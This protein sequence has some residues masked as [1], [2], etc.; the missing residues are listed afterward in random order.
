MKSAPLLQSEHQLVTQGLDSREQCEA[1]DDEQIFDHPTEANSSFLHVFFILL[2][3][4]IGSGTLLVPYCYTSGIGTAL[5]ISAIFAFVALSAM[6][7]LIY[8]STKIKRY[9]YH[10]M[11]EYC[12]GKK[13]V[14]ILNIMI[15]LV[16][17]GSSMIY[18][19]WNGRLLNYLIGSKHWLFG[20]NEF[21]VYAVTALIAFPLTLFRSISALGKFTM[22][23]ICFIVVLI[24]HAFYWFI[25]DKSQYGFDPRNELRFFDF[26][27]YNVIITALSVNSMAYN[28]HINLFSCLQHLKNSTIRRGKR[29]CYS[30]IIVA[31]ILYNLFGLFTYLDL[32][33]TLGNGSSL[34]YYK[35]KYWLTIFTICGVIFVLIISTPLVIW[36][37]RNSI[38]MLIWKD[39]PMTNLR[40]ICLGGGMCLLGSF[41]AASSDNV[42]LF[43]NVV[44]GLFTPTIIFLIPAIFYIKII[45]NGPFIKRINAYFVA[46]FTICAIAACTYESVKQ[47]YETIKG[48]E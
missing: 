48:D 26:K 47:I 31:F 29:F 32:F 15:F 10:E 2:N 34:E 23:S 44:G 21:Y 41:L 16:Q 7:F 42:L 8:S 24:T 17:F 12:F 9:D 20:S 36:A 3:S 18:S 5:I 25:K 46:I 27:K 39:K 22:L 28:C 33:N 14:W 1:C 35:G 11:F 40:W 45:K 19:H 6:N 37:A 30:V 13:K 4:A 38:N 43:F